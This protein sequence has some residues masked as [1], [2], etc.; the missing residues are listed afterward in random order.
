MN[1]TRLEET[2]AWR[3]FIA[4]R[5]LRYDGVIARGFDF[6]VL[7][8]SDAEG[9][10]LAARL[11][12][13]GRFSSD[14]ND[15]H[16]DRRAL[17]IQEY[18]VARHLA[19]HGVPVARPV[20][21]L[22]FDEMDV[23]VSEYLPDDG[24]G[25]DGEALGRTL[26][27]L[28]SAPPPA[29]RLVASENGQPTGE[30]LLRRIVRRWAELTRLEPGLPALPDP[31]ALAALLPSAGSLSLLHLDVRAANLRCQGRQ[32]ALVDW[33]N[34]LVGDPGLELA[35]V[36]EFASMPGNGIDLDGLLRGYGKRAVELAAMPGFAL[37]RLDAALMLAL[38]F[39]AEAPDPVLG[40]HWTTNAADR[41]TALG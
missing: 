9:R 17:L 24:A 12:H 16:V 15:P 28:H 21:L 23:L 34:A 22:L 25:V 10:R 18:E 3:S 36:T 37:Y 1:A 33:A 8:M 32:A 4:D 20:D 35:R 38:V 29:V 27:L 41:A 2:A 31:T 19:D 14:V 11:A 6:T 26:A 5:R 7:R 40:A 13:G 39:R 30:V